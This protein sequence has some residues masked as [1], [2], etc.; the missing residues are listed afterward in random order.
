MTLP[1]MPPQPG[2]GS[3]GRGTKLCCIKL[4]VKFPVEAGFTYDGEPQG[5][6]YPV[7]RIK[8]T[9][10]GDAWG[11]KDQAVGGQELELEVLGCDS[12]NRLI[13]FQT[14]MT[15]VE[16][17]TGSTTL[18]PYSRETQNIEVNLSVCFVCCT[19][20]LSDGTGKTQDC[21]ECCKLENFTAP[22]G[23]H[24]HGLG[25]WRTGFFRDNRECRTPAYAR[26][27][28]IGPP[29]DELKDLKDRMAS[30]L[31]SDVIGNLSKSYMQACCWEQEEGPPSLGPDGHPPPKRH[32]RP[33]P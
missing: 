27:I 14:A 5:W 21:E 29:G 6:F 32:T 8:I 10:P 11:S 12:S 31:R 19:C 22:G 4:K 3:S 23:G 1:I 33:T 20:L 15:P 2:Q 17:D 30:Q 7:G 26:P 13:D 18:D 16:V 25:M 9:E 28:Q 24:T